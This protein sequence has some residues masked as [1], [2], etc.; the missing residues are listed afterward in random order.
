[1]AVEI[2]DIVEIKSDD[3]RTNKKIGIVLLKEKLLAKYEKP[4]LTKYW[5][6]L[7]SRGEVG[8]KWISEGDFVREELIIIPKEK[9]A[10]KLKEVVE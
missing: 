1:M 7:L 6:K 9:L 4:A 2:G 3:I 8:Q 10:E 5:V